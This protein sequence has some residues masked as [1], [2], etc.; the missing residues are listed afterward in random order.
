MSENMRNLF[1][2]FYK[3]NDKE[4]SDFWEEGIFV[5]DT[6]MLLNVYRYA[7]ETRDRYFEILDIL[8]KRSQLWIPYQAAYEYQDRRLDVIRGQL[9][10]YTKVA[11]ILQT[12][13]QTLDSSLEPYKSKHGIIDT[14]DLA[15]QL[16]NAIK[17]AQDTV[18]QGNDKYRKYKQEN[19]ALKRRDK[20]LEKIE[21]LFQGNIGS[22][23]T[24]TRLEELYSQAQLRM[25]L[26]IPPGWEDEGKHPFKAYGDIV[27]WFQLIDYARTQEKPMAFVTD[28]GKKDWWIRDTKG[29]RIASREIIPMEKMLAPSLLRCLSPSHPMPVPMRGF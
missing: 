15:E 21:E 5:F 3:R 29:K 27:L 8:K 7:S 2:G 17:S 18:M 6:N 12:T 28:D 25:E 26:R 20:L 19:E 23:Y 11:S 16:T 13:W 10:P 24:S 1:P 14:T 4:L 22:P 9:E